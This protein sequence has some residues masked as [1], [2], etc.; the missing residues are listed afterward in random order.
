MTLSA[1][2]LLQVALPRVTDYVASSGPKS[3][4]LSSS[5]LAPRVTDYVAS[6]G[7][8]SHR[9]C[10][11]ALA[12]RVTDYVASSGPK[13][14]R[15]CSSALAPRVT[16][17]VAPLWAH[18]QADFL[19]DIREAVCAT[20]KGEAELLTLAI[21]VCSQSCGSPLKWLASG[22]FKTLKRMLIIM[23]KQYKTHT[24]GAVVQCEHAW[25]CVAV[26]MC[27]I[28][29]YIHSFIVSEDSFSKPE[30]FIH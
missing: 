27:R 25:F 12:P 23:I 5:A 15:L 1:R 21:A 24:H 9:L 13:S 14:H 29:L 8:K 10:S 7:P 11:S 22:E 17:Y 19:P 16:D 6:S 28:W 20:W 26:F 2:T 30:T 3:H 18:E 4:R